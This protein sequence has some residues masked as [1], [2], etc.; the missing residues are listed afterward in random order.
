MANSG[1]II[2]VD[3]DTDDLEIFT[4][5]LRRIGKNHE[6][7]WFKSSR[8]CLI[9]L[10]TTTQSPFI[11][12]CDINMPIQSGI[13][14]KHL[15]DEHPKLREKSIPFVFYSTSVDQELVTKAY[16]EMTVQ[17]FFQKKSNFDEIKEVLEAIVRY[18]E[19]CCH[20]NAGN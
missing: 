9:Y 11:I 3:D 5:A 12:F 17:G 19:H 8:E 7:I 16:T 20:P 6:V 2:L 13:E 15:I 10:E 14:F 18:W 1:P 4:D